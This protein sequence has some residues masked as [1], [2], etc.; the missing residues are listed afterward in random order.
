MKFVALLSGGKDSCYNIVHC[1]ANGHELVAAASLRPPAGQG[2]IDSFMYQ[3]VG[4]D[5]IEL[6]AEALGVPLLRR[7]IHGSAV[8]QGGEYG[9]RAGKADRESDGVNGDETEDMFALLSEVK[10]AYPDIQG[11]SVGAI[12]SNYQRV[13]VDHVQRLGLTPLCYLWQ[14]NQRELMSEMIAAG[15]EAILIKVAGIG[16]REQHL[17]KTLAQME[18]TF[19]QLNDKFGAHICG[20]GGE[21]ETLTLDCPVF[22]RR[23]TIKETEIVVHSDHSFATVAY[24]QIKDAIL[25]D[26][27]R[28]TASAPTIPP[29]LESFAVEIEHNL[30]EQQEHL[31]RESR[32]RT[33]VPTE[34]SSIDA[35]IIQQKDWVFISNVQCNFP[36]QDVPIE[37]E[38]A[39]CFETIKF[40][41]L[42][43]EPMK[44]FLK[45]SDLNLQ[46]K[47]IVNVMLLLSDMDLGPRVNQAYDQFFGTSPPSRACVAV[48]L[49][50]GTRFRVSCVAYKDH[51]TS[52]PRSG[53]HIQGISY[54]GPANIGPYSQAVTA[55]CQTFL[56]GQIG[57][58]PARMR[59]PSPPS[60]AK[61]AALA[62][63]HAER[64][65]GALKDG[66]TSV[67][68]SVIVWVAGE[69]KLELGR[70]AW[71]AYTQA[72][73]RGDTQ[74]PAVIVAA[75][76][77]PKGAMI[78]VQVLAHSNNLRLMGLDDDDDDNGPDTKLAQ[79]A[80]ESIARLGY[81]HQIRRIGEMS[82]FGLAF[83]NNEGLSNGLPELPLL[84]PE[85]LAVTV[86]HRL[87]ADLGGIPHCKAT[88][89][90][91]K[92]ILSPSGRPWD[93]AF[94]HSIELINLVKKLKPARPHERLH[95]FVEFSLTHVAS[96]FALYTSLLG[97]NCSPDMRIIK[98]WDEGEVEM[99]VAI[100]DSTGMFLDECW[101]PSVEGET[102]EIQWFASGPNS[103]SKLDV[104]ATP[105]LN[106]I[107][108][109]CGILSA[110]EWAQGNWGWLDGHQVGADMSRPFQFG[111]LELT[112]SDDP[113]VSAHSEDPY[114]IRVKLEWG[115]SRPQK[116]NHRASRH[117]FNCPEILKLLRKQEAL[118]GNF[119]SVILGEPVPSEVVLE[120][121]NFRRKRD[122]Q[123]AEFVFHYGPA[124]WL[125][126]NGINVNALHDSNSNKEIIDVDEIESEPEHSQETDS[127]LEPGKLL[128]PCYVHLLNKQ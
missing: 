10:A 103:Y 48:D 111:R 24:L 9:D 34:H 62:F 49:P 43:A 61:E 30:V 21:Y 68:Q 88:Y 44:A 108:V 53:L 7:T 105:Y 63:Q 2:E 45:G 38:V 122:L 19:H 35:Q 71:D 12:L 20:E 83:V 102:F 33:R 96:I 54:W 15:V 93:M 99:Q 47:H 115:R 87:D 66:S 114:T 77:L 67:L 69:D 50:E 23:I 59:L 121:H 85:T 40:T 86:F 107:E 79:V 78:E 74:I 60:F 55:Q 76:S 95:T 1:T 94:C 56:A 41:Q 118:A 18:P 51:P 100:V 28:T 72:S 46:L 104:R 39:S 92:G 127:D 90:P 27:P 31:V 80:T 117:S 13:R 126:A 119:T 8:E 110:D 97:R 81:E 128:M 29:L 70:H 84:H 42:L 36:T 65:L 11:V 22:K 82:S 91:V 57:L 106:G 73:K 116:L 14:R 37:N 16:L 124:D 25:E 112:D 109:D 6:V 98:D 26:K 3:T 32:T 123:P 113:A 64:I 75:K 5:A 101:I 52:N 89:I 17:G 58:I 125:Q 4:Q 120:T